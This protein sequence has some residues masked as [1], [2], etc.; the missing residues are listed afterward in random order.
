MATHQTTA[1]VALS[2]MAVPSSSPRTVSMTGVKGWYSA[3]QRSPV[4]IESMASGGNEKLPE[5]GCPAGGGG[6]V[7]R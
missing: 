7:G 6:M 5:S 3:S 4:G 1:M 2:P